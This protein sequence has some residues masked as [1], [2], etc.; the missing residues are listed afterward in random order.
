M[1]RIVASLLRS[2]TLLTA[3]LAANSAFAAVPMPNLANIDW[4]RTGLLAGAIALL[5]IV[6]A[7]AMSARRSAG[8]HDDGYLRRI[9]NMPAEPMEVREAP[10]GGSDEELGPRRRLEGKLPGLHA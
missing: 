7:V 4:Q 2:L 6:I 5:A 10:R 1:K 9:G 8:P 3:A